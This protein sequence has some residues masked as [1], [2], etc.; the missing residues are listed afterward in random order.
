MKRA[1]AMKPKHLSLYSLQIEPNTL[2]AKQGVEHADDDTEA[3]MYE[4]IMS[5]LPAAGFR[6]YE[7]SSFCIPGYESR[8][9]CAYW[10]YE[11]YYGIS[12]GASGKC[13][14]LRYDNTKNLNQYLK[15]PFLRKETHLCLDE[16]MFE[17]VMM[18]LR[19]KDGMSLSAFNNRFHKEFSDA[20][21]K[22]A[23]SLISRGLL[24]YAENR[25]R[26]TPS[27]YEIL[28]D[29]LSELMS[30]EVLAKGLQE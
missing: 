17:M 15:D 5:Y 12:A 23:A 18:G 10:N 14:Q 25:V 13:G 6:Q 9:N 21:S 26:C 1:L 20:F 27:G 24:E 28:N 16:S 22:P 2:F 19:L 29:V 30:D 11:D 7:I 8:H 3:D 4:W